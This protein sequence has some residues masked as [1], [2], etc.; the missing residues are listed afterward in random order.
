MKSTFSFLALLLV[1]SLYA[2]NDGF[3]SLF[4]GADLSE[5]KAASENPDCFTVD[6]GVLI[7]KGGRSHLFYNGPEG[8]EFKNFELHLQVKTLPGANSGVYFHTKYQA[9]GWPDAG[10]EAQVN[11][12]NQDSR[13]TG[14]LYGIVNIWVPADVEQKIVE[15][16]EKGEVFSHQYT[17]PSKDN[18]WFDYHITVQGN[19][20]SIRV[21]GVIQTEWTQPEGWEMGGR[22]IGSGTIG[23][24]A[25]DPDSEIHYRDIKI[26]VLD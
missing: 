20:V 6:D 25:H 17:A 24:Q 18:E 16:N 3:V 7:V 5:W 13:K 23:L 9:T 2:Q 11:T 26:K 21:N 15:V 14:S 8:T 1:C 22:R 4:N 19:K 10:F 12:T